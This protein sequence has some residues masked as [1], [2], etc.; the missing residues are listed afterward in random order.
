MD[1][2]FAPAEVGRVYRW[3]FWWFTKKEALELN[4]LARSVIEDPMLLERRISTKA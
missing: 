2:L 1:M 4:A 3:L